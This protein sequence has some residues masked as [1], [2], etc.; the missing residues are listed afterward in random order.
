MCGKIWPEYAVRPKMRRL[1]TF[2]LIVSYTKHEMTVN[3][4][5]LMLG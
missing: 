1:L 4:Q 3:V 5:S 2:Q